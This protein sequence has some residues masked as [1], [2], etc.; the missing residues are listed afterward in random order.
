[1]SDIRTF[2]DRLESVR[3][4]AEEGLDELAR[5]A[6]R[7]RD[8]REDIRLTRIHVDDIR[9]SRTWRVLEMYRRGRLR[10]GLSG[11]NV[12]A[13]QAAVRRRRVHRA[14]PAAVRDQP[15]GVNVAGYLDTESGMGEA[16]RASIRS[17]EAAGLP[18]A[19]NNVPSLLRTGDDSYRAAFRADNPQPFNLVHLNADNMPAFAAARGRRY[20]RGRYTIGYW[21]WELSSLRP[22]WAPFAGYVDEVWTATRF[23]REAVQAGCTVPVVRVP[24]PVVL[25]ELPPLGRASFRIPEG[26]RMFLYIFDVSSQTERK[27]P[28]AAI[29][30]FRRAALPHDAAVLVLKFTNPEYDRAGVRRLYE[31]AAGLNVVFLDRY[32]DR[33]DLCALINLADCYLSPHRAEG[34]GLTLLEAM[35]LGKPVIGTAY[36]GNTDFMTPENSYLLD[37]SLVTLTRDYGPYFRGAVWADPD[38]DHAARL[39]RDVVN[40][41]DEAAAR[42]ARAR[43]D[44]ERDWNPAVTGQAVRNRLEAIR[45]GRR[46][47]VTS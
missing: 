41:P 24:L 33:P 38:V 42:G 40:A 35:R 21:F 45:Q 34:F 46:L 37:Y 43:A 1:M 19:L 13:V 6:R 8:L 20:F 5:L 27:N 14:V 25:P 16:A 30:A 31:E 11:L 18:V 23:V 17:I 39:I 28:V 47:E 29:R 44:V 26:P 36:S 4:D 7:Q 15:P 22:D 3:R 2:L 10:A 32:L 9:N 12:T